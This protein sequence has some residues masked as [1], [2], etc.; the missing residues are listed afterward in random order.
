MLIR[1]GMLKLMFCCNYGARSKHLYAYQKGFFAA[2][3]RDI[4]PST[5]C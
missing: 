4:S 1:D 5:L 2:Q 3:R